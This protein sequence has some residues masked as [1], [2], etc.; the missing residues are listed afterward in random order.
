M[1]AEPFRD[2]PGAR[3]SL[4]AACA[5]ALQ[6]AESLLPH[7]LPGVRVGLANVFTLVA[8]VELGPGSGL[9]L[10]VLRTLVSSLVLGTFLGPAF[11]LSLGGGM[12]SAVVMG[13]GYLLARR[14]P[15]LGIIGVSVA[16]A[17]AH[18]LAQMVLVYLLFV[19]SSAVVRLAPWLVV[20]AVGAGLL[21]GFIAAH[22]L[23]RIAEAT[24]GQRRLRSG[25]AASAENL[26][27]PAPGPLERVAPEYK[28][29][30]TAVIA[31][32]LVITDRVW[33]YATV[34]AA[35]WSLAVFGRVR[36]AKLLAGLRPAWPL[37]GAAL[38]L[39]ALF[40]P[41][42]RIVLQLGPVRITDIGLMQ[43]GVFVARLLV[44]FLAARLLMLVTTP[45]DIGFGLARLLAPL[46]RLGLRTDSIA[47]AVA[48]T[49]AAF[50]V[51]VRCA[52]QAVRAR[53]A[54]HGWFGRLVRLPGAVVADLYLAASGEDG[55]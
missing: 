49:W 15:G 2:A 53:A 51:M 22:A 9:Q 13:A 52:Q 17:V 35:L 5:G 28:V 48:A 45:A 29:A 39:P 41:W 38:L 42:G 37:V 44:L 11:F 16:G 47:T 30:A 40:S 1:S 25:D 50:P 55:Q 43:A 7:P 31:L 54:G 36:L 26:R 12:A 27:L 14:L 6:V 3:L 24:G 33:V 18:T 34:F 23:G 8:I 21:T 32:V 46:R 10:A 19:R 20:F 4:L